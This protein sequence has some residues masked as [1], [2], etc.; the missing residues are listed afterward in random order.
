M[1]VGRAAA[2][3]RRTGRTIVLVSHSSR[4]AQGH[5]VLTVTGDPTVSAAIVAI[6]GEVARAEIREAIAAEGRQDGV[7]FVAVA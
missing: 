3:R 1:R 7:E 6:A 4:L 5:I 2:E